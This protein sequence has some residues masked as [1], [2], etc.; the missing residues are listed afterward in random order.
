MVLLF[1]K[2]EAQIKK[3]KTANCR[4]LTGINDSK[5]VDP[6]KNSLVLNCMTL[7]QRV[8]VLKVNTEKSVS[9]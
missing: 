1:C 9:Q 3:S 2:P 5:K 8:G 4:S 6:R 7:L